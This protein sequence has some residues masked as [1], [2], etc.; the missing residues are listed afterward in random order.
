[1]AKKDKKAPTVAELIVEAIT[2]NSE[3]GELIGQA[4]EK[5]GDKKVT[6]LLGK[7]GDLHTQLSDLLNGM[8]GTEESDGE[9]GGD[10]VSREDME[11][12]VV[13]AELVKNAKK[14]A[15]LGDDELKELFDSIESEEGG[16][17]GE[18]DVEKLRARAIELGMKEKKAKKADEDE[19]QAFIDENSDGEDGDDGD[20]EINLDELDDEEL[21]KL[22]VQLE[23]GKK[24]DLKE[25]KP[26]KLKKMIAEKVEGNDD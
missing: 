24:K 23:L 10:E 22:A 11:K 16:E 14:A 9:E 5:S 2:L 3:I 20:D 4:D 15:K 8:A 17:D 21:L 12:A 26:K 1:M 18:V 7:A 19:L 6:K 13:E 25:I